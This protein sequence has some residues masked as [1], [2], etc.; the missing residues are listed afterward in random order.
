MASFVLCYILLL[1]GHNVKGHVKNYVIERLVGQR[2]GIMKSSNLISRKNYKKEKISME[3]LEVIAKLK[4]SRKSRN[5]NGKQ[6]KRKTYVGFVRPKI[7][8]VSVKGS[9]GFVLHR[10]QVFEETAKPAPNKEIMKVMND[11]HKLK[12]NSL[13]VKYKMK[14]KMKMK[15][16][17]NTSV[18]LGLPMILPGL[19]S[20]WVQPQSSTGN[21][22]G[23]ERSGLSTKLIFSQLV[24]YSQKLICLLEDLWFTSAYAMISAAKEVLRFSLTNPV[25]RGLEAVKGV[26]KFWQT[27][28][29]RLRARLVAATMRLQLW[30][31]LVVEKWRMLCAGIFRS[32]TPGFTLR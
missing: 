31:W 14:K 10:K 2:Q 22:S 20:A 17:D 25:N 8:T 19:G 30:L 7:I 15:K 24:N 32:V 12:Q 9:K 27:R 5:G 3:E 28:A 11:S 6:M 1:T 18:S 29:L 26:F 21:K 13:L 23:H 16:L 4:D